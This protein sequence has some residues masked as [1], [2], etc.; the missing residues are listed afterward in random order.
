MATPSISGSDGTFVAKLNKRD[1]LE[2]GIGSV[3]AQ[4]AS[5][6]SIYN[7]PYNVSETEKANKINSVMYGHVNV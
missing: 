1:K 5:V 4:L 7:A 2:E 3:G 6:N